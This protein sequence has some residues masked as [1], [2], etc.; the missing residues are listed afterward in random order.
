[1]NCS[2]TLRPLFGFR[3]SISRAEF[4]R[5]HAVLLALAL[6]WC[7]LLVAEVVLAMY[8]LILGIGVF[9]LLGAAVYAVVGAV[10]LTL[11]AAGLAARRA[12]AIGYPG[13]TASLLVVP[14]A[15]L[16]WWLYLGLKHDPKPG[17]HSD[18]GASAL[19]AG[20]DGTMN[21]EKGEHARSMTSANR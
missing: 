13:G 15:G 11:G 14:V 12:R 16:G 2:T 6:A 10:L 19:A 3:G 8:T 9:L 20:A 7:L 4:W 1:M 17:S 21:Q 18:L 5:G